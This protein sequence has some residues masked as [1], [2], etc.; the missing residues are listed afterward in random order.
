MRRGI[1]YVAKRVRRRGFDGLLAIGV[2]L[3][4]LPKRLW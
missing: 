1:G 4:L 2:V 3:Q